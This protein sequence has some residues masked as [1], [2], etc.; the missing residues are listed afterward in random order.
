MARD[1]FRPLGIVHGPDARR[2]CDEGKAGA[3]GGSGLVAFTLV[4]VI[5]RDANRRVVPY[6]DVM[7]EEAV[8][9]ASQLRPAFAGMDLA[10]T[11]IM[12][13]VN[14][15]PDSFSDGGLH[16]G[17]AEAIAHARK[18]VNE[19][20][21]ILDV[22]GESTRPGS[23][24]VSEDE[25]MSRTLG[26]VAALAADG[27][28]VSIDTRKPAVME[29]AVKAGAAIINDVSALTYDADSLAM[30]AGLGKPVVLMHAQG[31]P[32]TMQLNPRYEDAALDVY[33]YLTERVS[34][35]RAAGIPDSSICIDPGIGFGKSF[36][37]NLEIMQRI[38]L[39][40]GLGVAVLVGVSR[41]GFIGAL[42]GEKLAINRGAGSVGGALYA[43][44]N[45]VHIVRVHDV[46]ETAAALAVAVGMADPDGVEF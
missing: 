45:G 41:K 1:Y 20:A 39:F 10:A 6:K 24:P 14:V 35:C 37:H 30:A 28:L 2:L 33:D 34:A 23:D 12:G 26:V 8:R 42:T 22:G 25:E 40:H 38:T 16:A 43:A 29:R 11:R 15:T 36:R 3:L 31:D 17:E 21:H 13:V 18:L 9:L 46:R 19:G 5:R 44:L 27:H 4:E 7:R 32:R